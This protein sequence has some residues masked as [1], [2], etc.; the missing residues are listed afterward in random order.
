MPTTEYLIISPTGFV[1]H[2]EYQ[3]KYHISMIEALNRIGL[4]FTTEKRILK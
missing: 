4:E 3:K 2:R 1:I